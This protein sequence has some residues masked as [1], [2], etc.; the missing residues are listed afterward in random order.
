MDC[1][2]LVAIVTRKIRVIGL[3][4]NLIQGTYRCFRLVS[5]LNDDLSICSIPLWLRS[6]EWFPKPFKREREGEREDHYQ[7]HNFVIV[8]S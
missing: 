7:I 2:R 1:K 6:L 8:K 4:M 3:M 5:P